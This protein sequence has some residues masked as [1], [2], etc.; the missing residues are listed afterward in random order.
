MG[1]F[2]SQ[3]KSLLAPTAEARVSECVGEAVCEKVH[4]NSGPESTVAL[5]SRGA[6]LICAVQNPGYCG[7]AHWC[8]GIVE[9]WK[10]KPVSGMRSL[11]QVVELC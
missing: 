11:Y 7:R 10:R 3:L 8:V 5:L 2:L 6:A 1:P 9:R 4:A